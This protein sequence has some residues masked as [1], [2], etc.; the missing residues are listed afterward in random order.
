VQPVLPFVGRV[1]EVA[2][3]AKL[4]EG[5]EA[6]RAGVLFVLGEPGV[7]KTRLLAEIFALA[8][9]SNVALARAAC[10]PL[11]TPLPFDPVLELL[12]ALRRSGES[13]ISIPKRTRAGVELFAA[14]VEAIE[15]V[16]AR[17]PVLLAL[18]DLQFSDTATRE[19]VHYCVS[20]LADLPVGWLIASRPAADV[21]ALA[22]YLT[23]DRLAVAV[24]LA[25][26]APDDLAEL[27]ASALPGAAPSD[28]LVDALYARTGGNAFLTEELLRAA[29]EADAV[30]DDHAEA[31][32][33]L[34]PATVADAIA[35]RIRRLSPAAREVLDWASILSEP[36]DFSLLRSVRTGVEA[37]PE[38]PVLTLASFLVELPEGGWRFSHS[39]VRDV[40][41]RSIPQAERE[42]RHGAVADALAVAHQAQRA[43]Q[44][45]GAGRPG[46]A[47]KAYLE[48]AGEALLRG[49][50]RDAAALYERAR[51]LAGLAGDRA[52][53]T[54][55]AAG[56][57]LALLRAGDEE[58]ALAHVDGVLR[59]LRREG[60]APLLEFLS[61]YALALWDDVSDLE[62][63]R[64]VLAEAEGLFDG[65]SGLVL[66][67][68]AAAQAHILDR[69]GEP[70]RALPFAERALA[71]ARELGDRLLEV[72]GLITLGLIVGQTRSAAEGIELLQEAVSLAAVED[73]PNEG[74]LAH[75]DLSY[76]SQ[77]SGDEIGGEEYARKGLE[78]RHISPAMEALLRGNVALGPMNRGE[79][80]TAL[81]YLLSA[82]AVA[83]RAG[84]KTAGRIAV[85]LAFVRV[86]RGELELAEQLL[87]SL[88]PPPGSWEHYR[89]L[90]PRGM[91]LEERG[92]HE[93][94]LGCYLEG[95]AVEDHPVALWCLAGAVKSAAALGDR[96]TAERSRAR[97]EELAPRWSASSWLLLAS[98]GFCESVAGRVDAAELLDEAASVCPEAFHAAGLRLEAARLR[99]DRA[100]VMEAIDAFDGMGARHAADRARAVARSL[101][102]RP[103]RRRRDEGP[104]SEREQ[105]IALLV[106]AGKTNAEVAAAL[107]LSPRTV[108]RHVGSILGK[109]GFRSR[110]EL[111][112]EVAAGRLPG[113][114]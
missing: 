19:L 84:P 80:D 37:E 6:G 5:L 45:E 55:A 31:L 18:D 12:R 14:A 63:A 22:H 114:V 62:R 34:V 32:E 7:G 77:V 79:L 66:A 102:L 86:M 72:R 85:Q 9:D 20:R 35:E 10:L 65:A 11:A 96:E 64:A 50:P 71:A 83:E 61:R 103:G 2:R 23:R 42:R 8:A 56:L 87:D 78:L 68:A 113:G 93:A 49:G 88:R 97:L 13:G 110:V 95:G 59:E 60:G 41:Y 3:G 16:A 51:A 54:D 111:A 38:L 4:L 74:A 109:L 101:G 40:V 91:L 107:Y 90:E 89:I 106:A 108:E 99:R 48:V 28:E 75:L 98:R 1:E 21:Q 29:V 33:E 44:L 92:V 69:G 82:E 81:A 27:V 24:E 26:L 105:E 47:A 100:G 104:L 39:I 43:P 15:R 36:I 58:A 46:E 73:L 53:E 17:R 52:V 57:V 112:A 70:A 76:L 67:E 30:V 25:G 94:A